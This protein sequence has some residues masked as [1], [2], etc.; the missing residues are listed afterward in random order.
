LR[1]A[2]D[3][4]EKYLKL[5]RKMPHYRNINIEERIKGKCFPDSE[6]DRLLCFMPTDSLLTIHIEAEHDRN[7]YEYL[8]CYYLLGL[9][10][11]RMK[12]FLLKYSSNPNWAPMPIH[13]Q[14]AALQLFIGD[15]EQLSRFPI[16]EKQFS[17]FRDFVQAVKSVQANRNLNTLKQTFGNTF[18]FYYQMM[19]AKKKNRL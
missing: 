11:D 9:D 15:S 6:S 17:R 1:G 8:G 16:D 5:L 14:E 2:K 7:A 18:W 19:S 13:F 10:T 3:V 4:E 12:E